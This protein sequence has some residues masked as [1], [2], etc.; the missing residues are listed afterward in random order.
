MKLSVFRTRQGLRENFFL[1]DVGQ[2]IHVPNSPKGE[3]KRIRVV[4]KPPS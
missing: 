4:K 3:V 2:I 1:K